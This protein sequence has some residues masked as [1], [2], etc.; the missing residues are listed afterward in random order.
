ML[1]A[2]AARARP[3]LA[4][5]GLLRMALGPER[6]GALR[7]HASG[8]VRVV[9]VAHIL[10]K[11][12]Q[13]ALLDEVEAKLAGGE[14]WEAVASATSI[15]NMSRNRAGELGWLKPNTFFPE[16]ETVAFGLDV[17]KTGR[18]TTPRG[19][20]LIRILNERQAKRSDRFDACKAR[21]NPLPLTGAQV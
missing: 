5:S 13:D 21:C 7:C 19:R 4:R 14:K 11:P 18:A 12:D 1:S 16:F 8:K 9:H 20:H 17:G 3:L 6:A 2:T 10:V 15:C